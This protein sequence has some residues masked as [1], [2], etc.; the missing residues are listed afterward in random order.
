MSRRKKEEINSDV[1]AL[2]IVAYGNV[3]I[4]NALGIIFTNL[5][6]LEF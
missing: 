5:G 3:H 6:V 4:Y 1:D 2:Y